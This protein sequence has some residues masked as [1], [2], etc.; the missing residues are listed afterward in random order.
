MKHPT[1]RRQL[2]D[3]YLTENSNIISGHVIDVGGKKEK[4]R[5][6][7]RPPTNKVSSWKYANIDSH[8]NPDYC[9]N[10]ENIPV[11]NCSFNTAILC[12]VIEHLE[13]VENVLY[14]IYR[15]LKPSGIL[16]LS[17]PF[18]YP[19]HADPFDFQRWTNKK[20][21]KS[22]V[23]VGFEVV[24]INSMGGIACVIYDLIL[25]SLKKFRIP[26]FSYVAISFLNFLMPLVKLI[27]KLSIRTSDYITGGY[28][29][30]AKKK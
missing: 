3:N 22:L 29:V 2:L 25:F 19:I 8:T 18:L 1:F 20:I 16:L 4:S 28:F 15:V 12:E 26:L 10:A 9:C 27:D 6:L 5:G 7:F 11:E 24:K 13:N 23:K 30:I 21:V 17:T 14:E